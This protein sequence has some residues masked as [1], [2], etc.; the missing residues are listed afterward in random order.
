MR[1]LTVTD[2]RHLAVTLTASPSQV[3]YPTPAR[4]PALADR[5]PLIAHLTVLRAVQK[6]AVAAQQEPLLRD[7][8]AHRDLCRLRVQ[9]MVFHWRLLGEEWEWACM[10]WGEAASYYRALQR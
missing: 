6:A 9:A 3:S 2:P 8:K 1:Q 7:E 5:P 4:K 10:V